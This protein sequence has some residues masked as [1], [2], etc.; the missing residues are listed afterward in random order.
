MFDLGDVVPL[1]VTVK[2]ANGQPANAGGVSV[3]VT[4]PDG[5]TATPTVT[6][7]ETGVYNA[8]YPTVQAG[9]HGVRWVATGANASAHTDVFEVLA[10][11]PRQIVSLVETKNH[12]N[13][14]LTKTT[15]D[16][17]LRGF[18]LATTEVV[19]NH[20][21]A[22][23]RTARVERFDGGNEAVVLSHAPV[24]SVTSV[25]ESGTAVDPSGYWL[26]A[27]SGVLRRVLGSMPYC[28]R[29]GAGNIEAAYVAGRTAVTANWS[30]A[31]LIIIQH[32]WETQRN[33][34]GGR[35]QLTETDL[36]TV[37]AAGSTF[38]IPRRALELLGPPVS[39]IA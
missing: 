3:T 18:V 33:T 15:D 5:T 14:S 20:V 1:S 30:R 28:W 21:G 13:L 31:A 27:E 32:M 26:D 35:P 25:T 2:D 17:E 19:E 12:L 6:S 8:D 16:A 38:S 39:G 23:V 7:P 9:R 22:V 10:A 34:G 29:Y 36:V 4:L 24:L 11:D 37:T